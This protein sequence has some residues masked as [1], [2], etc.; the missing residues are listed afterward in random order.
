[1]AASAGTILARW[2]QELKDWLFAMEYAPGLD[3]PVIEWDDWDKL[4][5]VLKDAYAV[6][7]ELAR[8]YAWQRSRS[9]EEIATEIRRR[10]V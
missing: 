5:A 10:Y 9:A 8:K 3:I 2:E 4:R 6:V 1:M 7:S